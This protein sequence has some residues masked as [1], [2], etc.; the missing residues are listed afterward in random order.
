MQTELGLEEYTGYIPPGD[1]QS[2]SDLK[3][4]QVAQLVK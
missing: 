2:Q 4:L 1:E 3:L